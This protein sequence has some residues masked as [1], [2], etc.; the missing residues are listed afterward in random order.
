[1]F[2]EEDTDH[3]FDDVGDV[4]ANE[5]TKTL[6]TRWKCVGE[7]WNRAGDSRSS[8]YRS[9]NHKRL[10]KNDALKNRPLTD[11]FSRKWLRTYVYTCLCIT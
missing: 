1:M 7:N 10:L 9:E 3:L 2:F 11:F 5:I 6:E 4:R 8:Y